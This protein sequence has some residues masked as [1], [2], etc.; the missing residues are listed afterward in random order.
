[1]RAAARA[2]SFLQC[3]TQ[4]ETD[5]C[6]LSHNH[7]QSETIRSAIENTN[8]TLHCTR[9]PDFRVRSGSNGSFCLMRTNLGFLIVCLPQSPRDRPLTGP[10][11]HTH[12]HR[13]TVE[14]WLESAEGDFLWWVKCLIESFQGGYESERS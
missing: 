14:R 7:K 2:L 13:H 10:D 11:P 3:L 4:T 9:M 12:T 1:M 6:N 8:I 5:R